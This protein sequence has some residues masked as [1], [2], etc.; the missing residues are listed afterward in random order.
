MTI[1]DEWNITAEQLTE[2]LD[3]NPSLRGMLLGYAAEVKLKEIIT[4]FPEVSYT[5]KFDDHNRKKKGDLYVVY[6]GKAFDIE[7]KSLQSSMIKY[8]D[9]KDEWSVIPPKKAST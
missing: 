6:H 7:S 3:A 4:S 8:D 9:E 2:M 5:T 1:L